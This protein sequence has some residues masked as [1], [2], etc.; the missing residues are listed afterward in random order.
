MDLK[1][2]INH[3]KEYFET[4][5]EL[6][7][8]QMAGSI[9]RVTSTIIMALIVATLGI[10]FL[11]FLNIAIAMLIADWLDNFFWG[12]LIVAGFYLVLLVLAVI[13]RKQ[14][15]LNPILNK[16]INIFYPYDP[17]EEEMNEN[18]NGEA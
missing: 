10:T 1:E 9:S 12:F 17:E 8:L 13:F 3:L 15:I 6:L 5:L 14:L 4:R 2:P 16:M 11:L 18:Y 7:K